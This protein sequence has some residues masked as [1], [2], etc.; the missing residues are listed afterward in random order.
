MTKNVDQKTN[1]KA[2]PASKIGSIYAAQPGYKIVATP[3]TPGV[4]VEELEDQIVGVGLF[5]MDDGTKQLCYAVEVPEDEGTLMKRDFERVKARNRRKNRCRIESPKTH[6]RIMCPFTRTCT[7]CPNAGKL[8]RT[9]DS[10][11]S[12]ERMA[13][14]G[15]SVPA[16]TFGSMKSSLQSLELNELVHRLIAEKPELLTLMVLRYAGLDDDEIWE[17]MGIGNTKFYKLLKELKNLV[18]DYVDFD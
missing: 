2:I 15:L 4:N 14:D 12:I 7:N 5:W 9:N 10:E 18:I 6:K 16:L 8:E 1:V 11:F 17:L 13:E 3:V